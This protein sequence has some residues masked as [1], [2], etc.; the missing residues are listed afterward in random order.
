[1]LAMGMEPDEI[2]ARCYEEWVRR[3]PLSDY[4]IPRTSLLRGERVRAML[5]RNLPGS[6]EELPRDFF[7]VSGDL[8]SGGLVVHRRGNLAEAVL[9]S[10]SVPGLISPTVM[11]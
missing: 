11:N 1:M 2:D 3:S 7:C 9:A 6:I 10:M 5:E 8:A 4:R